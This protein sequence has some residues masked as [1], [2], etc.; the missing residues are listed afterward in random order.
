[1]VILVLRLSRAVFVLTLGPIEL[2]RGGRACFMHAGRVDGW[3]IFTSL[4]SQ[5]K[6]RYF[7]HF[8]VERKQASAV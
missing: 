6:I 2:L 7:T 1:M 3:E 5:V 4:Y 8:L